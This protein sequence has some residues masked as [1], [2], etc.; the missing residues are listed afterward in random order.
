MTRRLNLRFLLVLLLIGVV[1]GGGAR[2]LYS[3]QSR[4]NRHA[5]RKQAERF[6]NEGQR[7]RAADYLKRYLLLAPTDVEA[8]VHYGQLI[9]TS[10]SSP[11]A[12]LE[13]FFALEKA[14]RLAPDRTDVRRE[15]V[16]LAM[17]EGVERFADAL[18]HLNLLLEARPEDGDL[19]FDL[20]RCHE[21]EGRYREARLWHEKAIRHAPLQMEGYVRLAYL[22]RRY[23]TEVK[24]AEEKLAEL[25][26]RADHFMKT[27]TEA[28]GK[29]HRAYLHRARYQLEF[30]S[31]SEAEED[32]ARARGLAPD[33]AD[34]LTLAAELKQVR[35]EHDE[36]RRLLRH[37]LELHPEN[38]SLYR[39]L[40]RLE[41]LAGRRAEAIARLRQGLEAL[42]GHAE[43]VW[44]LADVL[45]QSGETQEAANQIAQLRS[46]EY[47]SGLVGYLEGRLLLAQE[48]WLEAAHVLEI[49]RPLVGRFLEVALPTDLMLGQSYEQMGDVDRQFAAY[50]RAALLAPLS[51]PACLGLGNALTAMGQL[52]E[53][54]DVYRR[55]AR[56][57]P[58]ARVLIVHLLVQR[59]LRLPPARRDWQEVEQALLEAEKAVPE[60]VELVLVKVEVLLARNALDEARVILEQARRKYPRRV[61]PWLT[62]ADLLQAQGQGNA[63]LSLL[64]EATRQLGDRPELRLAA[65]QFWTRQ[66][67]PQA[68]D[69]LNELS[70]GLEAYRS[71]PRRRLLTSLAEA[72]VR[73]GDLARARQL[74]SQLVEL[75]PFDLNNR[76]ALFDL[77]LQAG[78]GP[79]MKQLLA[80]L[81]QVEGPDGSLWRYSRLRHLL[82]QARGGN[83]EVLPEARALTTTLTSER[84]SWSRL[85]LCEAEID[86]LE[87]NPSG[88]LPNYLRAIELGER[89]PLVVRRTVQLLYER[90]R[91][92][93]ADRLLRKL[94]E[95]APTVGLQKLAAEVSFHTRDYER[96]LQL[97]QEAVPADSADYRDHLW[98]GQLFRAMRQAER[99]EASF[100]RAVALAGNVA[101]VWVALTQFLVGSGQPEKAEAAIRQAEQNLP[102][103]Q[104]RLALAQCHEA[105]GRLDRAE[106]LY[107]AAAKAAPE[108]IVVLKSVADFYLRNSRLRGARPPL[109]KILTLQRATT[110]DLAWARRALAVVLAAAGDYHQSR[111]A[112]S[113]LGLLDEPGLPPAGELNAAED[114]RAQALVLASQPGRRAR[115]RAVEVLEGV[116]AQQ[117]GSA[118]DL[119]LLARLHDALDNWPRARERYQA[120]LALNG[121]NQACLTAYVFGLLRRKDLGE[122]M[123]WF[124]RLEKFDPRSDRTVELKVRLLKAQ[125]Q[126]AEAVAVL[127]THAQ[128]TDGRTGFA[129]RLLERIGEKGAAE[130]MYLHWANQPGQPGGTAALAQFLGRQGK[131]DQALDVCEHQVW[132]LLPAETAAA[133][134]VGVLYASP[135]TPAQCERVERWVEMALR[136]QPE[137]A[138]LLN[139]LGAVHNRQGQ[140]ERAVAVYRQAVAGEKPLP[141]AMN[142][143]AWLLAIREGKGAEAMALVER[144]MVVLGPVPDLLDTRAVVHLL[145]GRPDL[146]VK[147]LEEA[148]A[149]AP[150]P[151]GYFHLAHAYHSAGN[152]EA[153]ALA[154]KRARA[155]GLGEDRLHPLEQPV[156]RRLAAALGA[157]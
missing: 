9:S 61:E 11:T 4:Q 88:V 25:P 97:A 80:D 74:R 116:L 89:N 96:A 122:A 136:K 106:E 151:E 14:L 131:L 157:E 50:R 148:L 63:V 21:A 22:L 81:R 15:A 90:R 26:A 104:C 118:E 147:D 126:G 42:P 128:G 48:R 47:P 5:L 33:D 100:R 58:R 76:L 140:Y 139:H 84:P 113:L 13:A 49:V 91:Y 46:A 124:A 51:V 39:S 98:L 95:Q 142:N 112:L 132:R 93:E 16:R 130:K 146:A 23:P 70:D 105:V 86:E 137:A 62:Q 78:D 155:E 109:E 43:L 69:W 31:I 107:Q 99:A 72:F 111:R 129:A 153:A 103:D 20:G 24:G 34:V 30:H 2:W 75:A 133:V 56:H 135:P 145:Q 71:G 41:L 38:G 27:L 3:Y 65:V 40:A 85:A 44:Y 138:V 156:Y 94:A 60:A 123:V 7:D 52:D 143:L 10:P 77:A 79:R 67:G 18:A 54:L 134:S 144:A 154:L 12:R 64:E 117:T 28:N 115:R 127:L 53:A 114:R 73:V 149:E 125:N 82:W 37:A 121:E 102:M 120:S 92:I 66:G 29:D 141:E 57:S 83:K 110:E 45:L 32:T 35:G 101:D 36:A 68:R 152:A 87:G 55:I 17:S 19:E 150:S 108:D 8:L 59:N 6:E 1:L 119:F